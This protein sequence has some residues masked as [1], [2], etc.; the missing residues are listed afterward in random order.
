MAVPPCVGPTGW[1]AGFDE[2]RRRIRLGAMM[3]EPRSEERALRSKF[4]LILS[5]SVPQNV[6]LGL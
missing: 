4:M 2:A 3:P 1:V 6:A 5:V